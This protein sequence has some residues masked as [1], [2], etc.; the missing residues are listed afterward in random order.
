[1]QQ[2]EECPCVYYPLLTLQFQ[3]PVS[4]PGC[5]CHE[6]ICH[7]I[8]MCW[9]PLGRENGLPNGPKYGQGTLSQVHPEPWTEHF[10]LLR[11][12]QRPLIGVGGTG[13]GVGERRQDGDRA[14]QRSRVY[15]S[16]SGHRTDWR[17]GGF[18]SGDQ[19]VSFLQPVSG[20]QFC[21]HQNVRATAASSH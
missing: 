2:C 13:V 8:L 11:I 20:E 5:A 4:S 3:W 7:G 18:C 16:W 1:M 15:S 17:G 21:P 19:L 12:R 10:S 14:A 9:K 6:H